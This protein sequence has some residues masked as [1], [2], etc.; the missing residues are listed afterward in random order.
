MR[1]QNALW[2]AK[3]SL[4]GEIELLPLHWNVPFSTAFQ[5]LAGNRLIVG[6]F[7]NSLGPVKFAELDFNTGA[8]LHEKTVGSATSSSGYAVDMNGGVAGV[9]FANSSADKIVFESFYR[10]PTGPLPSGSDPTWSTQHHE[11][12]SDAGFGQAYFLAGVQGPDGLAWFFFA[13]DSAK[14][15]GLIRFRIEGQSLVLVD[16]TR[17]WIDDETDGLSPSGENFNICAVADRAGNRIL[18]AYQNWPHGAAACQYGGIT[19]RYALTEVRPDKSAALLAC[20]EWHDRHINYALPSLFLLGGQLVYVLAFQNADCSRGWNI[21]KF[22]GQFRTFAQWEPGKVFA[23]STDGWVL[24]L[25]EATNMSDLIR[26]WSAPK[27]S[28]AKSLYGVRINW[29]PALPTNV[30]QEQTDYGWQDIR[31]GMPPVELPVQAGQR[32][33]RVRQDA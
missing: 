15:I 20:T 17:R 11:F 23:R 1:Y 14:V 7:G 26:V 5:A 29:T 4:E 3:W 33:Y 10:A 25:D 24:S 31:I 18:L 21:G 28:I 12:P 8:V 13:S 9:I 16:F 6:S 2:L 22:D 19:S 27:L 32:I 30:L